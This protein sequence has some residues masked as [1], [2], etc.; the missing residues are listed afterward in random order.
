MVFWKRL[1]SSVFLWAVLLFALFKLG[2][3]ASW[4]LT[5]LISSIALAEFYDILTQQNLKSFKFGGLLGGAVLLSGSWWHGQY[6]PQFLA[7]FEML[8]LLCFV[9]GVF[10]RQLPQNKNPE[11]IETMA[12]TLLGLMYIPFLMS[13]IPKINYLYGLNGPGPLFV[14]YV[15]A[16]TKCCDIGAYLVGRTLGRHKMTLRISPNK[17]WEGAFGGVVFSLITSYTLFQIWG[18]AWTQVGFT[19][20]HAIITG[21]LLG[22]VAIIG[23][24]SESLIKREANIHD[25]GGVLPGIG[26][27]LD[28]IDSL[29]FTAPAMYAYLVLVI[30][31]NL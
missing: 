7:T 27:A 24:L 6:E 20:N 28:L 11:A 26:G 16:V 2:N 13:F 8:T 30:N 9:M 5:L 12:Y 4:A 29:L 3:L 22:T 10:I 15:V 19:Q 18:K 23:D 1:S 21:L 31:W 14:F 17:T 25:S